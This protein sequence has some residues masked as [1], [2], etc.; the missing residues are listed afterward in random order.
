MDG[1]TQTGSESEKPLIR[2]KIAEYDRCI[3]EAQGQG[4]S[5]TSS[6]EAMLPLRPEIAAAISGT[7]EEPKT[8]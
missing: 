4:Q 5:V 3:A 1:T 2:D 8:L 7:P 6:M